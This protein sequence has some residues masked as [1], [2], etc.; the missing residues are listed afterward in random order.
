[1]NVYSQMIPID[2][3]QASFPQLEIAWQTALEYGD[4]E[5]VF[6]SMNR[7]IAGRFY[8]GDSLRSIKTS[9]Q[10]HILEM[11]KKQEKNYSVST[12]LFLQTI[13]N[14][15]DHVRDVLRVAPSAASAA[16][17]PMV[18]HRFRS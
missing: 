12:K 13:L 5:E 18:L 2:P 6:G 17:V 8:F 11:N 15:P 16:I 9:A 1:M 3:A 7:E 10:S 14:L 4:R